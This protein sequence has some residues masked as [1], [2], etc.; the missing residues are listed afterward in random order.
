MLVNL[1][2]IERMVAISIKI[3]LMENS[4]F[5]IAYDVPFSKDITVDCYKH[6]LIDHIFGLMIES[7]IGL[8][9]IF[10]AEW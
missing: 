2:N 5:E 3:L 4:D 6:A 8:P 10:Y 1:K 7:R 9:I